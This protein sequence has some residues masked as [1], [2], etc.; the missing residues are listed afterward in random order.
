ML[1]YGVAADATDEYIKIG[2][3]TAIECVKRFC[4]AIREIYGEYY[5][6]S[7][8]A[9]DVARFLYIGKQCG[10]PGMLGSLDCMY[11]RWKNCPKSWAA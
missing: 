4:K 11:W 8:N 2:E 5:L 7:P 10:F 1:A 6:R 3:Y 9:N